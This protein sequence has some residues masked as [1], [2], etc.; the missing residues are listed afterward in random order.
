VA[1]ARCSPLD[2]LY[3]RLG[4]AAFWKR[5][6]AD[7]A[8]WRELVVAHHADLVRPYRAGDVAEGKWLVR[9]GPV[10]LAVLR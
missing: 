7:R 1:L 8:W 5:M 9:Q 3:E 10:C 4:I 2:D 6:V